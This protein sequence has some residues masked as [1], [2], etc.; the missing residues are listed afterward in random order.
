MYIWYINFATKTEH[1]YFKFSLL[2]VNPTSNAVDNNE[3]FSLGCN[4]D[5]TTS[6]E[7]GSCGPGT[8]PDRQS[9]TPPSTS[10][11]QSDMSTNGVV[12]GQVMGGDSGHYSSFHSTSSFGSITTTNATHG[13]KGKNSQNGIICIP[14]A[15]TPRSSGVFILIL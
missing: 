15:I 8:S 9:R 11:Y 10:D 4:G 5:D 13:T 2:L 6:G 3:Y 14:V 12:N 7:S 1:I